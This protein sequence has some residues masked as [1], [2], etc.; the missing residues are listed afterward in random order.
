MREGRLHDGGEQRQQSRPIYR[1]RLSLA[2]ERVSVV[3]IL[4]ER[5][6]FS[7][8]FLAIFRSFHR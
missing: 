7:I 1:I 2:R 6:I 5:V 8:S 3:K 4:F